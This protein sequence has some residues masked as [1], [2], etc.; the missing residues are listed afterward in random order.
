MLFRVFAVS[1]TLVAVAALM[2][3]RAP[4]PAQPAPEA[5]AL[6]APAIREF[7]PAPARFAEAS[8][9]KEPAPAPSPPQI[10][11][12]QISTPPALE[13]TAPQTYALPPAALPPATLAPA[14]LPT[15]TYP[16]AYTAAP[17]NRPGARQAT[18]TRARDGHFWFDATINGA[19]ARFLF[20]TGASR[21]GIRHEEAL[22]LG[23]NPA[24]LTFS[25]KVQTANGPG[26][27]AP[28]TIDTMTIGGIT[29]RA[30]PAFVARPGA[31]ATNLL[32]QSFMGR[33]REFNTVG[34]TMVL[35]GQ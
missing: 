18:A 8:P 21:T 1:C 5:K 25:V 34:D 11:T 29:A 33:L 30:V 7:D 6:A 24:N 2:V 19:P 13:R 28:T 4:K 12:P 9:L 32:G 31:L 3:W 27:V 16:G 23:I 20:D 15:V 14:A 22:A 26:E 10:A 17:G 35:V